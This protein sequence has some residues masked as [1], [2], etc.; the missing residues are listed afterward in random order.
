MNMIAKTGGD[1]PQAG[2]ATCRPMGAFAMGDA[3]CAPH[4]VECAGASLPGVPNG[5]PVNV[6][7]ER[8]D[9]GVRAGV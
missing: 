6:Q 7:G 1:I 3:V 4:Y 8:S 9:P 5:D 2:S